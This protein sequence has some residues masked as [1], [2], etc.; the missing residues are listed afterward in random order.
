[1]QNPVLHHGVFVFMRYAPKLLKNQGFLLKVHNK[2][3]NRY[4]PK[5]RI[6]PSRKA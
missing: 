3:H 4:A 2:V 1:M 6:N 5:T